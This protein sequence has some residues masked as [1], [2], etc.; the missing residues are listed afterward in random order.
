M[1]QTSSLEGSPN[2]IKE[3]MACSCPVV[4]SDVGDTK[5]NIENTEGCFITS[6]EVDDIAEK[7]QLAISFGKRTNGRKD[8]DRLNDQ[9]IAKQIVK[10][11]EDLL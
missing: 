11:Y 6:Y 8:I 1:L 9:N 5:Q 10:I 4:S 3:A 2:V 7:I